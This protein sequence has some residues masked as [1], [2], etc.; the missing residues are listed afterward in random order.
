MEVFVFKPRIFF[1]LSF[2]LLI[3][4]YRTLMTEENH[5]LH[6][7]TRMN[8]RFEETKNY[9][10]QRHLNDPT[11]YIRKLLSIKCISSI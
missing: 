1:C 8:S 3:G 4:K 9:S 2:Y 7:I 5:F 11:Q 10:F 6:I